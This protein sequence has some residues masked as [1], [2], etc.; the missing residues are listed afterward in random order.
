MWRKR[1]FIV[2]VVLATVALVGGVTGS[3]LAQ[4]G[5]EGENQPQAQRAALLDRV[6]EIYGDNTGTTIDSEALKDAFV[7]ARGEMRTEAMQNRLH[8]MVEQGKITQEQ[9]DQYKEWQQSRPDVP[10]RFGFKGHGRTGGC[11]ESCLSAQNSPT[12]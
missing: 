11:G 6:C 1:K 10:L 7:Q 5:N 4:N 12:Y 3:V 2:A 8:N 9:A